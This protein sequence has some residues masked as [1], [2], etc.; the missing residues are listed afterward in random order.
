MKNKK[1]YYN[2]IMGN[3]ADSFKNLFERRW[4]EYIDRFPTV[5]KEARQ[6]R[7]GNRLR[8]CMVCWGYALSTA[9]IDEMDFE[10]IIDLA[11]GI[12]LIHKGSIIIDDYID[13]DSARR[14]EITFHK[15]FSSNET[16]MF[17]L[18]LLGKA[19]EKLTK[20]VNNNRVSQ[21]ICAMSESALRELRL[22]TNNFFE[23]GEIDQIVKGETIALIKDSLLFG[24]EVKNQTM[25]QMNTIL[26]SVSTKCAYSFQLLNDLEPFTAI[27]QNIQNKHNH[28]FDFEKNRKNLVI[29]RLYQECYPKDKE[30]IKAHIN[31]CELIDVLIS[32]M[33]KYR[34]EESVINE[35]EKSKIEM[36]E[37]LSGLKV[38]TSNLQCLE[39][40]LYFIN[41]IMDLCYL[42][43]ERMD[44]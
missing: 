13:D 39:D 17:L 6:L 14:G 9:A 10:E 25:S 38:A 40:F 33:K 4:I 2:T 22:T 3:G 35:V 19:V 27:D 30:L 26:E 20:Y 32:L 8:P 12:E 41:N 1:E 18:F 29:A 36:T 23:T 24:Y 42:R 21:L 11:I 28:N 16:I 37:E 15:Q 7:I 31:D 5:H 34:I 44:E 43:I